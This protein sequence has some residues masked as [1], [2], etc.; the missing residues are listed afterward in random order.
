MTIQ[1]TTHLNF[2]S[3]ARAA[4]TFYQS[5]FGGEIAMNISIV[6][7]FHRMSSDKKLS[8]SHLVCFSGQRCLLWTHYCS[9]VFEKHTMEIVSKLQVLQSRV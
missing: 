4:L 5:V 3:Q 9:S 1:T 8:R 7:Y 6:V 2:R